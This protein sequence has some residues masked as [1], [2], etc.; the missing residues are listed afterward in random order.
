M[1]EKGMPEGFDWRAITPE[2]SPMTPM[3]VFANPVHQD[4]STAAVTEGEPAFFFKRPLFDF[5]NGTKV[6]TGIEFDLQ[7]ITAEK[8]VAL[9][10]GSYT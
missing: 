8:P 1:A 7:Q 5:S 9:I 2:D 10:F 3:D 6:E 4:L